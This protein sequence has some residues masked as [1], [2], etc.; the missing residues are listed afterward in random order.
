MGSIRTSNTTEKKLEELVKVRKSEADH[1][2]AVTKVSVTADLV[3]KAHRRE[4]K[5]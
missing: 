5:K 2:P 1:P 4:V 3:A